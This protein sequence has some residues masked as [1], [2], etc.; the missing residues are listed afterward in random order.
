MTRATTL[1]GLKTGTKKVIYSTSTASKC[2]NVWSPKVPCLNGI[3]MRTYKQGGAIPWDS[4]TYGGVMT[5]AWGVDGTVL[6]F[7]SWGNYLIW[8]CMSSSIQ[9]LCVALLNT[10]T[11]LGTSSVISCP[12]ESWETA[13]AAVNEAPAALY[14]GG[15]ITLTC[16]GSCCWTSSHALGLLTWDSSTNPAASAAWSR[17]TL[18]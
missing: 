5:S 4:F 17:R 11:S 2:C 14:Y 3:S 16:S 15:K 7:N 10:P 1:N 13:G 8:S 12:T 9:C 18:S 6:N